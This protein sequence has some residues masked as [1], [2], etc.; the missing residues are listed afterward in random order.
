MAEVTGWTLADRNYGS[1]RLA[2]QLPGQE[3]GWGPPPRGNAAR[4]SGRRPG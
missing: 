2:D 1:P 3:G 4:G